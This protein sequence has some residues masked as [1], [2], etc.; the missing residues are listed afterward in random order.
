MTVSCRWNTQS[1]SQCYGL[2]PVIK[3]LLLEIYVSLKLLQDQQMH[4][5]TCL[6][7]HQRLF[8]L[9]PGQTQ[10]THIGYKLQN[11]I[12]IVWE[13]YNFETSLTFRVWVVYHT[14]LIKFG[15]LNSVFSGLTDQQSNSLDQVTFDWHEPEHFKMRVLRSWPE[16]AVKSRPTLENHFGSCLWG[17]HRKEDCD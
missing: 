10:L 16:F 12:S 4:E 2:S 7:F 6:V 11:S 5:I 8:F 1:I 13:N 17:D 15:V 14:Q 9:Y 3:A